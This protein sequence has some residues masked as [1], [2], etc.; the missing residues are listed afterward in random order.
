MIIQGRQEEAL[1]KAVRD[2]AE[3]AMAVYARDFTVEQ[4]ADK[5]PV[6]EADLAVDAVLSDALT[7]LFPSVPV[8]T[9]EQAATHTVKVDDAPFF[10]VDPIDGT[11]EF[12]NKTGEFTVNVALIENRRPVYGIVYAP[13]V[14][15]MFIGGE[16]ASEECAGAKR[17][18]TVA[19]CQGA[20]R[21]VASR[22]HNNDPTQAFLD[23]HDIAE[24]VSA[25]SSL[26]FCLLAAGE[27]DVYPRFGPTMEWDTAAGHAVLVAAGGT[28]LLEDGSELVYGKPEFRNPHFIACSPDARAKCGLAE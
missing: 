12:V 26:K 25:G 18:I 13:A 8:V 11:K 27:A 23:T 21:A 15:R 20:M 22:S 24:K 9:E 16:T 1:L 7:S 5:S 3:L 28:V 2:A 17:P 19:G 4:K 10:L 14:D 6:T